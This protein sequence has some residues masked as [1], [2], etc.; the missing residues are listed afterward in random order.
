VLL[1]AVVVCPLIRIDQAETNFG[2]M[3]VIPAK[4]GI[5]IGAGETGFPLS[6][7]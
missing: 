3:S 4:A 7:E 6:R 1:K 2:L 5:Q